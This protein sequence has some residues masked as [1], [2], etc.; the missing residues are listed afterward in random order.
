LIRQ[1]IV[2]AKPDLLFVGLGSP[3]QEYWISDW[4]ESIETKL[5]IGVGVSFSFVAGDVRRA[6]KCFQQIGMEWL[7]RLAMEPRRLWKRYL[8]DDIKFFKLLSVQLARG[9]LGFGS[10]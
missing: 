2:D 7:W 10:K 5:A 8:V 9:W 3:K 6:P 1:K 4:L